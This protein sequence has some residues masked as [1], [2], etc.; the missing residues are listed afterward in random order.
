MMRLLMPLLLLMGCESVY[1]ATLPDGM[2]LVEVH[3]TDHQALVAVCGLDAEACSIVQGNICA[4]HLPL[5]WNGDPMYR[6]HEIRHCS[7]A[8]D[9]PKVNR[10]IK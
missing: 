9:A 4:I 3:Y 1:N 7:G 2:T 5:A 6:D 10:N 8:I